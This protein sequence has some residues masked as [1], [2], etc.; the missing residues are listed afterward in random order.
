MLFAGGVLDADHPGQFAGARVPAED[1][2]GGDGGVSEIADEEIAMV[3]EFDEERSDHRGIL[4]DDR[5]LA[6]VGMD[7][8]DTALIGG[9]ADDE[10]VTCGIDTEPFGIAEITGLG[11][12]D[13]D[14]AGFR[15]DADDGTA[16]PGGVPTPG[17]EKEVA[18]HRIEGQVAWEQAG[19]ERGEKGLGTGL[20]VHA[21]EAV[22][23][24]GNFVDDVEESVG[25]GELPGV[26]HDAAG[27]FPGGDE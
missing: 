12:L 3:G 21:D 27:D 16:A 15:A 23:L 17:G 6:G 7:A 18:G 11:D 10:D 1:G 25:V 13:G 24:H 9:T 8:I 26:G 19:S 4:G 14:G 22:F 20:D 5:L 2:S